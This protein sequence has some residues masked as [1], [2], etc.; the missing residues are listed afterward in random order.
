MKLGFYGCG[1]MGEAI[2][3]NVLRKELFS[4]LQIRV[5][6]PVE[7]RRWQLQGD[8]GVMV[9]DGPKEL[10]ECGLVILGF[11]PQN[12]P[13]VV[14]LEE[15]NVTVSL[16]AGTTISDVK[17]VFKNTKIVRCMPNLP[18]KYGSGMT[19]LCYEDRSALSIDEAE[20]VNSI[21]ASGGAVLDLEEESKMNAFTVLC[22]SGP[23]YFLY[24][25]EMMERA[26]ERFGFTSEEAEVMIR[27]VLK[28]GADMVKNAP[29]AIS[30]E[31]LRMQ[32][33]SK[34]GVTE[35]V[36]DQMGGLDLLLKEA[37][38]AGVDRGEALSK[39]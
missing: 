14:P 1:N 28:G 27:Q 5:Y 31:E 17:S 8:Y 22:G 34:G 7:S 25:A 4:P 24:L 21:F 37:L 9:C 38:A 6:E 11:K 35:A 33:T 30:L 32:I 3:R 26:T 18:L 16:L 10:E 12:L 2:L 13:D 20:M 29:S 36:V 39:K 19:A 23:A 15:A